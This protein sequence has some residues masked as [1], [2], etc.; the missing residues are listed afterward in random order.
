MQALFDATVRLRKGDDPE[1]VISSLNMDLG[2]AG[3]N[4]DDV[5]E[6]ADGRTFT[7][8]LSMP[9]PDVLGGFKIGKMR[10]GK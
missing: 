2:H 3:I 8:L 9:V 1:A 6:H 4:V 10:L 5:L 7:F